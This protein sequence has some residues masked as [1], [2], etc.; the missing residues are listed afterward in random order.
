MRE[1]KVVVTEDRPF[2]LLC[3]KYWNEMDSGR[4]NSNK[5]SRIYK[6]LINGKWYYPKDIAEQNTSGIRYEIDKKHQAESTDL[7]EELTITHEAPLPI[8][9]KMAIYR[10]GE[11]SQYVLSI[12]E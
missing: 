7:T 6:L 12:D 8:I 11:I 10:D 3:N 9:V 4:V 1:E 5:N 2:T